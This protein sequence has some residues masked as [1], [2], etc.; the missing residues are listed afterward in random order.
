MRAGRCGVTLAPCAHRQPGLPAPRGLRLAP[1]PHRAGA[2]PWPPGGARP[3]AAG[4]E[5]ALSPSGAVTRVP[6]F[7]PA[8]E[9][10]RSALCSPCDPRVPS[11]PMSPPR[12]PCCLCP[13]IFPCSTVP[14]VP[15]SPSPL[16][17]PAPATRT[18][19]VWGVAAPQTCPGPAQ[20]GD[21]FSR[22]AWQDVA[23]HG[24]PQMAAAPP[25]YSSV[26]PGCEGTWAVGPDI[27]CPGGSIKAQ[28]V[29]LQGR[30]VAETPGRSPGARH[31]CAQCPPAW[32]STLAGHGGHGRGQ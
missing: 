25:V 24:E 23:S 9:P 28:A 14:P 13:C 29:A 17:G 21:G 16:H 11:P 19:R 1:C 18:H 3:P 4:T 31:P 7:P 2:L 6:E 20:G 22:R 10:L 8:C 32:G 26:R 5:A 15:V 27:A 12:P 30:E